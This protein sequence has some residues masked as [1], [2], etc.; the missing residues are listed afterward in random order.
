MQKFNTIQHQS[1]HLQGIF[2]RGIVNNGYAN[3]T[4]MFAQRTRNLPSAGILRGTQDN[5]VARAVY[6]CA[7]YSWR[8]LVV[9]NL[10]VYFWIGHDRFP[11]RIPAFHLDWLGHFCNKGT[12]AKL[13]ETKCVQ[14]ILVCILS[15]IGYT[16]LADFVHPRK[17]VRSAGT[18][19]SYLTQSVLGPGRATF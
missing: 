11:Q 13:P 10:Q 3:K 9:L 18:Y 6:V 12:F 15:H 2:S 4:E 7:G 19:F 16:N 14:S 8:Y 5:A 17:L 1:G